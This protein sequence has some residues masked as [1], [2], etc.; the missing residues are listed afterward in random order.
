MPFF[1]RQIL[2][3][4]TTTTWFGMWH[5]SHFSWI[6]ITSKETN[7]LT[8]LYRSD[9]TGLIQNCEKDMHATYEKSSNLQTRVYFPWQTKKTAMKKNSIWLGTLVFFSVRA[10]YFRNQ[11]SL[12][13][14]YIYRLQRTPHIWGLLAGLASKNK[15]EIQKKN[16]RKKVNLKG[17]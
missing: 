11:V 17:Y 13:Y 1:W 15:I 6:W 9:A 12:I 7:R 2:S 4:P 10:V 14:I 3:H 16:Y 5:F 8:E